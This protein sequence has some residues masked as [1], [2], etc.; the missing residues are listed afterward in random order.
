MRRRFRWTIRTGLA[1]ATGALAFAALA[2]VGAAVSP[3]ATPAA[4]EQYPKKVTICHKT[5]SKKNP[6]RTIRVSRNAVKAHLRHGDRLGPCST[7]T[8]VVCHKAKG[9]DKAKHTIKVKGAKAAVKHLRHGDKLGKCKKPK[10]DKSSERG[11][12][13]DKGKPGKEKGKP[14]DKPGKGGE[15]GKP[16]DKPGESGEKGKPPETPGNGGDKGKG[17]KK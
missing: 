17:P 6:F 13:S 4:S 7:A 14:S 16:S 12:G 5:G 11:K 10:K 15:K 1:G 9:K 3:S 2:S 8:F